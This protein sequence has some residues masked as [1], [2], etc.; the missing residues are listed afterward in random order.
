VGDG[1]WRTNSW[2]SKIT[3]QVV[4]TALYIKQVYSDGSNGQK[5][6]GQNSF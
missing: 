1:R 3:F 6:F 5:I 4:N 2:D